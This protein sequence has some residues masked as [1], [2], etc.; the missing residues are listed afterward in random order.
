MSKIEIVGKIG[1]TEEVLDEADNKKD[2]EE[3]VDFWREL[4]PG[5][6]I[7]TQP[8]KTLDKKT[9]IGYSLSQRSKK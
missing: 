7:K 9:K 1:G 8:K 3:Q 6:R 2:A 5:W 4:L